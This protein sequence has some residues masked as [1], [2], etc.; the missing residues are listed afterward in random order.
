MSVKEIVTHKK[1]G[2]YTYTIPAGVSTVEIHIWGAGGASGQGG[3]STQ[4]VSGKEAVG[5]QIVGQVQTGTTE[6][7]RVQVG[8]VATGT[9]EIGTRVVTPGVPET[10]IPAGSQTYSSAGSYT[11][12]LPAGVKTATVSVT[13][14][15]GA[16]AVQTTGT[17]NSK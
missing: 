7:G 6:V 4:V 5:T 13:G 3:V 9:V 1:A 12:V 16:A 11:A 15:S 14:G 10:T 17:S 2:T 8:Q